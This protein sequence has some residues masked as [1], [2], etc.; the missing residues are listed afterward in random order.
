MPTSTLHFRDLL[1]AA[2]LRHGTD[3]F[4]SH[5]KEGMLRILLPLK[6]WWLRLGFNP[7]TWV[8]KASPLP[9]DHQSHWGKGLISR[10]EM[11][12]K[13][14]YSFW[15]FQTLKTRAIHHLKM[16]RT[17]HPATKCHTLEEHLTQF[18]PSAWN[19][20]CKD[21]WPLHDPHSHMRT[22]VKKKHPKLISY[23]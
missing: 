20:K 13:N 2:N 12:N 7:Q 18:Q 21:Y 15:T 19:S 9:L 14:S 8:P 17:K 23:I 3:S 10:V 11:S 6:I 22:H 5:L 16:P 4:T 1:H